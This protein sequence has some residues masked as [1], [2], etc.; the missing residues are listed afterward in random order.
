[1]SPCCLQRVPSC[2]RPRVGGPA[3]FTATPRR[4]AF[5]GGRRTAVGREQ[6]RLQS[7]PIRVRVRVRVRVRREGTSGSTEPWLHVKFRVSF[8][9]Q[10]Q[11]HQEL[12]IVVEPIVMSTKQSERIG[13]TGDGGLRLS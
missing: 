10:V 1:M 8:R 7:H 13:G 12:D 2:Q 9:L 3:T 4:A 6:L 5:I 11:G